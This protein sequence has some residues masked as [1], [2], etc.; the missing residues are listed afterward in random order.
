MLL[1]GVVIG[2]VFGALLSPLSYAP[3]TSDDACS[4]LQ[5]EKTTLSN[6]RL[7][8]DDLLSDDQCM[9]HVHYRAVLKN[10]EPGVV[11]AVTACQVTSIT[12]NDVQYRNPNWCEKVVGIS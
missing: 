4:E 3:S 9:G 8:W 1:I 5:R 2:F 12:I 6:M 7:Y 11:D 10:L